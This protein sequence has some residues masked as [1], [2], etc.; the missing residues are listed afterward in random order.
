MRHAFFFLILFLALPSLV[1]AEEEGISY[2]VLIFNH[3]AMNGS[4][5]AW[6]EHSP[7]YEELDG[8][9]MPIYIGY[10]IEI[11]D[12]DF[13]RVKYLEF[14]RTSDLK[15]VD[16]IERRLKDIEKAEALI[17]P[18]R[19]VLTIDHPEFMRFFVEKMYDMGV[20]TIYSEGYFSLDPYPLEPKFTAKDFEF[21]NI[22][23]YRPF[24]N[25]PEF[26]NKLEVKLKNKPEPKKPATAK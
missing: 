1:S 19:G 6:P 5:L 18:D 21:E 14:V 26:C 8:M 24:D 16:Y 17:A 12:S 3:L 10:Y 4:A 13:E 15:T 22:C 20:E 7:R 2:D 9:E 25:P 11:V 23:V